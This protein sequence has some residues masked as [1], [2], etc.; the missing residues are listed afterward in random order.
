[1]STFIAPLEQVLKGAMFQ[2][3]VQRNSTSVLWTDIQATE[4]FTTQLAR[5]TVSKTSRSE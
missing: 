3:H 1:M 5:S 2:G 4:P